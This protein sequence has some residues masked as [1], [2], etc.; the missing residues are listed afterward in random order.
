M[1]VVN[2]VKMT[3]LVVVVSGGNDGFGGCCQCGESDGSGFVANVV[4][5]TG[6]WL[7]SMG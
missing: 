6:W 1:V 5:V 4:N 2:V 7:W 3:G